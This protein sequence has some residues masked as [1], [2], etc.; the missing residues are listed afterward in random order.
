LEALQIRQPK[1][2]PHGGMPLRA[3]GG[4]RRCL[5]A[6]NSLIIPHPPIACSSL[7]QIAVTS[8]QPKLSWPPLVSCLVGVHVKASPGARARA[9]TITPHW[10]STFNVHRRTR[11]CS[12]REARARNA[13][14]TG[15][16]N[17]RTSPAGFKTV[18][19]VLVRC[20]GTIASHWCSTFNVHGRTSRW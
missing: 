20:T 13:K 6:A 8:R 3:T 16:K 9:G 15:G 4:T 2:Q 19:S 11:P 18:C 10:Y 1:R 17:A 14:P 5:E 12:L 7:V